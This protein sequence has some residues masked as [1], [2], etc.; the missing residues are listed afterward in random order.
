M[1]TSTETTTKTNYYFFRALAVLAALALAMSLSVQAAK[2]PDAAPPSG[3]AFAWGA[4][5]NGELGNGNAGAD[6]NVPVAV[7]KLKGVKSVEAGCDHGLALKKDGTVWAWGS[8]D[9]GQLGTANAGTDSA[10][11][12]KVDN[13]SNVEAVSAGCY[14]SLALT[15]DG[16]VWA[17]GDNYDGQ[18]GNGDSGFGADSSV[19]VEVEDLQDVKAIAGGSSFSLALKEDGTVFAWGFN[20]NG[21]LGD[22]NAGSNSD[23]QVKVSIFGVFVPLTGVEA[24]SAASGAS[25]GTHSLALK[26][27]GTVYT[28]GYG[29]DGNAGDGHLTDDE[30]HVAV[31]VHNLTGVRA[32]AAGSDFSL[33]LE[34]DG[35][36]SS[37][38][39]NWQGQLG[40][41]TFEVKGAPVAVENLSGVESISAGASHSLALKEN[42]AVFA[43]GFNS[44]GELGNGE[45]GPAKNL[46]VKVK[47][48]TG[49]EYISADSGFSLAVRK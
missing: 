47:N 28:W 48:L 23:V 40:D 12:V 14:H 25:V 29:A 34:N 42:G 11:P 18:L 5:Y 24:I 35:T 1:M 38:G 6:K 4:N 49:V 32:V 45:T 13:L 21:E 9:L 10:V 7:K 20:A 46:P 2:P 36:V 8:D 43:W 33:A 17:W 22:A 44:S 41:G 3:R 30:N 15:E 27:N 16:A 26:E 31:P 37:W 19:P 39:E